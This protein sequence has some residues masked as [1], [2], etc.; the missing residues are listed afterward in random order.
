MSGELWQVEMI[1]SA[2]IIAKPGSCAMT[3]PDAPLLPA[4]E[5]VD[6]SDEPELPAAVVEPVVSD[7]LP[8][9][10]VVE[11]EEPASAVVEPEPALPVV[12][13]S[14]EPE[15]DDA[16]AEVED[17]PDPVVAPEPVVEFI[18]LE[19]DCAALRPLR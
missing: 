14:D 19:L 2:L 10:P 7:E 13:V 3:A 8:E 12:L 5:V 6:V 9:V 17:E 11:P 15:P 16:S 4:A 18:A 1:W